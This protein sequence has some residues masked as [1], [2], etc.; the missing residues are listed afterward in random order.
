MQIRFLIKLKGFI[1]WKVQVAREKHFS[2]TLITAF[3]TRNI[4]VRACASTG[5]AAT[6]LIKST[7]IHSLFYVSNEL[8]ANTLPKLGC[9][10]LKA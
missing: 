2:N 1:F 8:E 6:L 3:M 5:I 7:T 9:E 10:C 4:K